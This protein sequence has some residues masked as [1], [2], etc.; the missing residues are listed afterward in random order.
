MKRRRTYEPLP[1]LSDDP[2]EVLVARAARIRRRG[3]DRKARQILRTA[4]LMDEWRSRTFALLG[5]WLVAA[6]QPEEGRER[7]RHARWLCLR[8]GEQGRAHALDG[9]IA[10]A[11]ETAA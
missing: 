3:D 1:I 8:A 6:G 9:L 10:H 2:I 11:G 4:C 7:F 5:A